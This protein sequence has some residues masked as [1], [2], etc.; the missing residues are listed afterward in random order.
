MDCT[1]VSW[2]HCLSSVPI[3]YDLS[4]TGLI[5]GCVISPHN[6][7]HS[8]IPSVLYCSVSAVSLVICVRHLLLGSQNTTNCVSLLVSPY[9]EYSS[10]I[11]YCIPLWLAHIL[12]VVWVAIYAFL[13]KRASSYLILACP[14]MTDRIPLSVYQLS[15]SVVRITPCRFLIFTSK[16]LTDSTPDESCANL[17]PVGI[18]APPAQGLNAH[19]E[20]GTSFQVLKYVSSSLTNVGAVFINWDTARSPRSSVHENAPLRNQEVSRLGTV[21]CWTG[22]PWPIGVSGC[23]RSILVF[24]LLDAHKPIRRVTDKNL[25][26]I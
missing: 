6:A 21:R 3:L 12:A 22:C 13:A 9:A 11:V 16:V 2:F 17:L 23:V 15:P 1:W 5:T 24:A 26:H 20:R 14:L 25:P 18:V 19:S 7:A 8:L 10:V 4:E